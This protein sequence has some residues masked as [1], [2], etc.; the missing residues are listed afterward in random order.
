V[1]LSGGGLLLDLEQNGARLAMGPHGLNC[2]APHLHQA[3]EAE[4]GATQAHSTRESDVANL[5]R[6]PC[7]GEAAAAATEQVARFVYC[8]AWS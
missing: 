2:C 7:L 4:M 8:A 1:R 5:H 6:L 3:A